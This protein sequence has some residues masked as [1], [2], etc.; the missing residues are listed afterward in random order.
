[1]KPSSRTDYERRIN[2]VLDYIIENSGRELFLEDLARVSAFS[3]YHFQRI[4][5]AFTGES[6][7]L[8]QRRVRLDKAAFQ[9]RYK[10][11]K[12]ITDIAYSLGFN[13][14]SSFNR[15]FKS[16]FG[17][18]PG[19]ARNGGIPGGS[20]RSVNRPDSITQI[21][22]ETLEPALVFYRR[23]SG[24]YFDGSV[25]KVW[26]GHIE[27]ALSRQII[28]EDSRFIGIVL[29]TPEITE[30][31][32]CRY[33]CCITVGKI[34]DEN[35]KELSGGLHGCFDVT[36]RNIS[37]IIEAYNWIYGT[38]LLENKCEPADSPAYEE[39]PNFKPG[40]INGGQTE[41]SYRICIPIVLR[42]EKNR[43][44]KTD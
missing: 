12:S 4:F 15:A 35:V 33:D 13:S 43:Q 37:D 44:L 42:H 14:S 24:S 41:S 30:D 39:Y 26:C 20:G 32:R 10:R 18:T 21:S 29:D 22:L 5:R 40:K 17:Q 6:A 1:M 19:E 25:N 38:W 27:N 36:Y 16:R 2:R 34:A 7:G 9:L 31:D 8:Y 3:P 11:D 23:F 28:N